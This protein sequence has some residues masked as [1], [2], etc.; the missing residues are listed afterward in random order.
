MI[1]NI[2][3]DNVVIKNITFI[4]AKSAD[5]CGAVWWEGAYGDLSVVVL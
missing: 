4:N 3:A 1:F 5:D 2:Q